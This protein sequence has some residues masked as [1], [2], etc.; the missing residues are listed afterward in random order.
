VPKGAEVLLETRLPYLSADQRRVVLKTTALGSGYPVLDDPGGWGRLN[1]FAAADGY[2]QFNGSVTISMDASQGGFNAADTWRNDIGGAGKLTL[3]GTGALTLAGANT[4]TGGTQVRGGTLIAGSRQAFGTGDVY[5]SAGTVAIAAP[6]RASIAGNYTQLKAGTL[7]IDRGRGRRRPSCRD[8]AHDHRRRHA[9]CEA[10]KRRG[11]EP[12]R[13]RRC[14]GCQP[15]DGAIRLGGGR[16]PSGDGFVRIVGCAGAHRRLNAVSADG[17]VQ[18]SKEQSK[19]IKAARGR[20]ANL[21]FELRLLNRGQ[22]LLE[23]GHATF[24]LFQTRPRSEQ[25]LRLR[26]EF[27]PR[28]EIE[29]RKAL[30][31]HSLHVALQVFGRRVFEQLT[32]AVL[33]ILKKITRLFHVG[34]PSLHKK[35][36]ACLSARAHG[37]QT[38]EIGASKACARA[39]MS[40]VGA[41]PE[42]G[43]VGTL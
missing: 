10:R 28:D 13:H 41:Y 21:H 35:R 40:A 5:V 15:V 18:G 38:N 39:P 8:G 16:W 20:P 19:K 4:Y 30:R 23:L 2:G 27:F 34:S 36:A 29:L 11:A 33:K 17:V 43:G 24:E 9:T 25:Y 32:H 3:N 6:A 7:A 37:A 1:L 26:I 14:G 12:G 31:E 42:F 22:A